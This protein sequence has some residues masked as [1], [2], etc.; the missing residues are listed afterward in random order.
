MC[1][2]VNLQQ[3]VSCYLLS[4]YG[5]VTVRHT[6]ACALNANNRYAGCLLHFLCCWREMEKDRKKSHRILKKNKKG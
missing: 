2:I 6:S 3:S 4:C 1:F 5:S